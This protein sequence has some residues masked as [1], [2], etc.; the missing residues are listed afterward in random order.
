MLP[1]VH[2][3]ASTGLLVFFLGSTCPLLLARLI[4][5]GP[6]IKLKIIQHTDSFFRE[7]VLLTRNVLLVLRAQVH[8]PPC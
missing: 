7:P 2:S 3:K 8:Y 5:G 4:L 6:P 1:S